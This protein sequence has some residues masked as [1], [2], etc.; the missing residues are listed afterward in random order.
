MVITPTVRGLLGLT[1][2]DG[3]RVLRFTPQL[4]ANWDSL[5]I[6]NIMSAAS[7]RAYDLHL[8]RGRGFTRIT[9]RPR[10][11][12]NTQPA[13]LDALPAQLIVTLPLPLDAQWRGSECGHGCFNMRLSNDGDSR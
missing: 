3:G 12:S 13:P 2:Q 8:T 6:N 9:L 11:S 10:V 7:A 4:P 1:W 5:E